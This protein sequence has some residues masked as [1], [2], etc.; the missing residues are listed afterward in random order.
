MVV[1]DIKGLGCIVHLR[2]NITSPEPHHLQ[3][4]VLQM[5]WDHEK[6]PSVE[7]PIGDLFGIGFGFSEKMNSAFHIGIGPSRTRPLQRCLR[8]ASV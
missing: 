4:H 8:Y 1:A 5:H 6:D 2:D 7:S 3:L